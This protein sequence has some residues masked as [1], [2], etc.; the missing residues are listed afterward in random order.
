MKAA[1]NSITRLDSLGKRTWVSSLDSA[2]PQTSNR[3]PG[4]STRERQ[5]SNR[6]RTFKLSGGV[7][8]LLTDDMYHVLIGNLGG[9]TLCQAG[10]ATCLRKRTCSS[11]RPVKL[12]SSPQPSYE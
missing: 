5:S 6:S 2:D 8:R 11:R 7:A 12:L 10:I 3:E 4:A 1:R 9:T